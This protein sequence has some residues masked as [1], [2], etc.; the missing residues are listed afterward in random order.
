MRI[1]TITLL[2]SVLSILLTAQEAPWKLKKSADGIEVYYRS[3]PN[4]PI[5][6]LRIKTSI[7]AGMPAV[8]SV[9]RDFSRY[10]QWIYKCTEASLLEKASEREFIYYGVMDF[11]WPLTDRD[12]I[13]RSR[14][15]KD[16]GT[17]VVHI[18]VRGLPQYKPIIKDRIRIPEMRYHWTLTPEKDIV[19]VDYQ[20]RSDPGG[21]L[22]AWVINLGLDQGPVQTIKNLRQRAMK[23]SSNLVNLA[24]IENREEPNP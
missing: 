13:A 6:E 1:P 8:L 23:S 7:R 5:N 12:F 11:P 3:S 15:T 17:G 20:L 2:L 18:E 21:A 19:M 24:A 14:M 4:S 22:P 9:M 10:P 16:P